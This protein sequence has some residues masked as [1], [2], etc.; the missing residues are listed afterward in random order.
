M[1]A[2]KVVVRVTIG[3]RE[4]PIDYP[5][6]YGFRLELPI[7]NK[8]GD[9]VELWW[10]VPNEEQHLAALGFLVLDIGRARILEVGQ[11]R[12]PEYVHCV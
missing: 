11:Y 10:N 6:P 1:A 4:L 3:I 12:R 9:P 8:A 7:V 5:G 2:G